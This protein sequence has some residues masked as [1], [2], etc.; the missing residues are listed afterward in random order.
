MSHH[1]INQAWEI[2]LRGSTKIVLLAL[3]HLSAVSTCECTA[4]ISRLAY[5]CG[6]S[7]S[8]V[9]QQLATLIELGRVDELRDGRAVHYRVMVGRPDGHA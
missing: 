2:E 8:G 5:I 7:D 1:L 4:T 6:M 9:R 3:C